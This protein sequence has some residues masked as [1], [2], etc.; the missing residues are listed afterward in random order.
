MLAKC[1]LI[2]TKQIF[3]IN[4]LKDNIV[5]FVDFAIKVLDN[6]HDAE[7]SQLIYIQWLAYPNWTHLDIFILQH[8]QGVPINK[9]ICL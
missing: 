4:R 7:K 6:S 2:E 9:H 1:H 3:A 5:R 8:A